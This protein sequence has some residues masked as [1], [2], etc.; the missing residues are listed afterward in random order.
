MANFRSVD[1][2]IH[3]PDWIKKKNTT[4]NP[5]NEDDQCF[6]HAVTVELNYEEI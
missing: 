5:K 3:F 6:Q 2:Y 1:S 4:I